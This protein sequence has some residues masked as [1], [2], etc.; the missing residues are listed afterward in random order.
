M[1]T[2]YKI[3]EYDGPIHCLCQWCQE[4]Q[5]YDF[6]TFHR[7]ATMMKDVDALNRGPYHRVATTYYA[8]TTAICTRDSLC[9]AAAY[10]SST[11][12]TILEKGKLNLKSVNDWKLSPYNLMHSAVIVADIGNALHI[13]Q[14]PLSTLVSMQ[15][16]QVTASISE[17]AKH[18]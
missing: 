18:T 10:D 8:M 15:L 9:N 14:S 13:P 17:S 16:T 12:D 7:P 3:L 4:L 1:K 11:L 6:V 5:G 2:T